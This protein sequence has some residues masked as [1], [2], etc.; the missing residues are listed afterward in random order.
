SL[1]LPVGRD[2]GGGTDN[3]ASQ[4][5]V[6]AA[7]P[8]S[9]TIGAGHLNYDA[10]IPHLFHCAFVALAGRRNRATSASGCMYMY[11]PVGVPRGKADVRSEMAPDGRANCITAIGLSMTIKGVFPPKCIGSLSLRGRGSQVAGRRSGLQAAVG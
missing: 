7:W 1:V 11:R 5:A 4:G 2:R 6:G 9:T 8:I 3:G 10:I